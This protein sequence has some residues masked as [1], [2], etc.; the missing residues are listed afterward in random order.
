[1]PGARIVIT[2][3]SMLSPSNVI[4][5]PTSAKN[6]MYASLPMFDCSDS[7]A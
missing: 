6:A 1:M 7:G 5:M 3:T 2:V 4:E